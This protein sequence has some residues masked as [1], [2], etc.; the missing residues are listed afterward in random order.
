[1]AAESD[2]P[3][4]VQGHHNLRDLALDGGLAEVGGERVRDGPLVLHNE[5]LESVQ[6]RQA[7]GLRQL[8]KTSSHVTP[9]DFFHHECNGRVLQIP[10]RGSG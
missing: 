3:A 8:Q 6:L 7:P 5:L 1:M 10:E 9:S 2:S 4:L